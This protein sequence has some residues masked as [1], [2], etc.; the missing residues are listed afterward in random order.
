MIGK[1]WESMGT[2]TRN[3]GLLAGF[4]PNILE[5]LMFLP[6]GHPL[7]WG[8]ILGESVT[9]SFFTSTMA[10]LR[11]TNIAIENGHF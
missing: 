6:V 8:I 4:Y 1:S 9:V 11:E 7:S 10:T 2:S 5:S 3:G